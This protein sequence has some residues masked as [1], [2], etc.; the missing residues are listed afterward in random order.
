MTIDGLSSSAPSHSPRGIGLS[1]RLEHWFVRFDRWAGRL[2]SA[3]GAVA[4][5]GWL[6]GRLSG[7]RDD[8]AAGLIIGIWVAPVGAL[9]LLAGRALRLRWRGR[10]L[11]QAM[12]WVWLVGF[13]GLFAVVFG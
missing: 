3:F 11:L 2:L 7:M 9:F 6:A 5:G 1:K 13:W 10:W 4:A 8:T 12:P